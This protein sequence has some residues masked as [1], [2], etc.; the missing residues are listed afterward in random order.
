MFTTFGVLIERPD[1]AIHAMHDVLLKNTVAVN[2][3]DQKAGGNPWIGRHKIVVY[4][5]FISFLWAFHIFKCNPVSLFI[6]QNHLLPR[7]SI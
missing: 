3:A 2:L 4:F 6:A 1:G 7:C 5:R